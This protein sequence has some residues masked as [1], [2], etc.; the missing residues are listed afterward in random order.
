MV[1]FGF[2]DFNDK[3]SD[4]YFQYQWTNRFSE[5]INLYITY[6]YQHN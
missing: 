3:I 2:V 1:L 6:L 4:I 5:S